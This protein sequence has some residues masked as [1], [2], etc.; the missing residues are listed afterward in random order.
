MGLLG[1]E[2]L[3]LRC[4]TELVDEGD[5]AY[6]VRQAC[7]EPD[8]IRR[9]G[10]RLHREFLLDEAIWYYDFG[11][12]RFLHALH[13]REGRLR[14]LETAERGPTGPADG[15][16][17]P[18]EIVIGMP[19]FRLLEVCGK[20]IQKEARYGGLSRRSRHS[21]YPVVQRVLVEEWIYVF[22]DRYLPRII[23]LEDGE[24]VSVET[25]TR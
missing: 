11:P 10:D 9:L 3:A 13:F 12:T 21:S 23:R 15:R 2:A 19:A 5:Y 20:P 16:C 7:G 22:D 1:G 17:V 6:E 24:V 18:S 8:A 25:K 4:G 14:R